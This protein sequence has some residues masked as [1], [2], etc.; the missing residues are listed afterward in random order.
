MNEAARQ[1]PAARPTVLDHRAAG[2]HATAHPPQGLREH[3][4]VSV[5][6][7]LSAVATDAGLSSLDGAVRL[8][9]ASNEAWKVGDVVVRISWSGDRERLRR[10]VMVLEHLPS[11]VP[12]PEVLGHGTTS[13]RTWTLTRWVPGSVAVSTWPSMPSATRD[14][15]ARQL[16]EALAALHQ[17]SPLAE[18]REQVAQRASAATVDDLIGQ[19]VNPLPVDR[20]L[21]IVDAAKQAPHADPSVIDAVAERLE[22]LRAFDVVDGDRT[23]IH[24]DLHLSNVIE[25]DGSLQTLLDFEWVRLGPPDLDLQAFLRAEEEAESIDVIPRL[26]EHYPSIVAHP[27]IVERLW[28][29]DLACT[30]RDV[31]VCPATTAPADLQPHH[32]LR[33]LAEIVQSPVYIER[34]LD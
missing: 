28:L 34:L 20:A 5:D 15:F 6:G 9:S 29:Y 32:P 25:V 14:R 26:A 21:A 12:H 3:A 4:A 23:V 7:L 24:G 8:Q 10:E 27:R 1:P 13:G 18:V 16:A 17:W 19:D 33:R 2:G 30:L 22:E 11:S 31:I